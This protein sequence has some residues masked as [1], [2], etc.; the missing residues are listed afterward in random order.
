[1]ITD[2]TVRLRAIAMPVGRPMMK[3]TSTARVVTSSRSMLS[4]QRPKIPKKSVEITTSM[5][6]RSPATAHVIHARR[7]TTP[8]Q[9]ISGTGRGKA[10]MLTSFCRNTKTLLKTSP[11]K[12]STPPKNQL[13]GPCSCTQS[14]NSLSLSWKAVVSWSPS[15]RVFWPLSTA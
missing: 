15:S 6:E 4:C 3:Q 11:M 14:R 8:S 7:A 2:D 10:G 1:M 9:P 5:V 13:S 12:P